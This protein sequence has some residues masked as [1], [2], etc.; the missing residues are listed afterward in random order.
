MD[1]YDAARVEDRTGV[2]LL[3]AETEPGGPFAELHHWLSEEMGAFGFFRPYDAFRGGFNP[4]PWHLSFAPEAAPA[5]AALTPAVLARA[6]GEEAPI[7][8]LADL[9]PRLGEIHT[10]Y[11]LNVA[12]VPSRLRPGAG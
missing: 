4:E 12:T 8:G 3:P 11:V 5:L 6:L 9:L 2:Q 7:D 10:V 1:V